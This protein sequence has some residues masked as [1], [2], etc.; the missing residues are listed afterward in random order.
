VKNLT[1]NEIIALY[2]ERSESAIDETAKQYNTYCTTIAMN[3][4]QNRE[5]ADECVNDTYMKLWNT[6]PPERPKPFSTY[7]GRI[8]RNLSLKKAKMQNAQKR[9]GGAVDVLLS[10]VELCVP[11]A[12]NVEN[13]VMASDLTQEIERFMAIIKEEDAAYFLCRYWRFESVSTIAKKHSVGVSKV[14][15]S[16][17]RTRKKLKTYLEERG[18]V[19]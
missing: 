2:V 16:L 6:I 15:V 8:V 19:V 5:D 13:E 17:H 9:G 14:K 4:L 18:I 12:H 7:I 10:E 3:I 11:S 1:D